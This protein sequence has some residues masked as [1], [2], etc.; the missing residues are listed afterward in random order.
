[1]ILNFI[2][3]WPMSTRRVNWIKGLPAVLLLWVVATEAAPVAVGDQPDADFLEFLGTWTSRDDKTKKWVDPF[4]LDEPVLSGTGE[5]TDDRSARDQRDP[6]QKQR[7]D[8]NPSPEPS[9]S[10]V[11]PGGGMK[12]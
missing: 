9:A 2:T 7:H 5:P 6:R 12:P 8:D 1:M 3:G 11:R 10:P 4:Q